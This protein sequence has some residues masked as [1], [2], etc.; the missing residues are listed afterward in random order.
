MTD[1]PAGS[2]PLRFVFIVSYGRSGS[3]LLQR[4]LNSA[5]GVCIRGENKDLFLHLVKAWVMF[6]TD[7][8]LRNLRR[9]PTVPHPDN[10][11]YGMHLTDSTR[12]GR[13]LAELFIRELLCPP[14]GTLVSGFKEIRW[15][16]EPEL[17]ESRMEFL[18]TFFPGARFIINTR[19]HAD[20]ARSGWWGTMPPEKVMPSL[21]AA[22]EMF[23]DWQARHP[24][25]SHHLHFNDYV[26]DIDKLK[27]AF[28]L[29]G[30]PFDPQRIRDVLKIRLQ[31]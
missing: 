16:N 19:N 20:V 17:F 18:K 6:D 29:A 14:E 1:I 15:G 2:A 25:I 24:D 30:L 27:P 4:I 28:D 26:K 23:L 7:P 3:T 13:S 12:F 9:S 5:D 22:E 10:P 21:R 31:H 8:E 11:W